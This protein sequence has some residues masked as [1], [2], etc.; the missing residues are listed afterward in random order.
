MFEEPETVANW[1]D[2]CYWVFMHTPAHG[3]FT[4]RHASNTLSFELSN[5]HL[6]LWESGRSNFSNF[7][8]GTFSAI[9]MQCSLSELM[10]V[11][12]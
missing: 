2:E 8:Y 10:F 5:E 6:F 4:L 9:V 7:F 3:V 12:R 11:M 1:T